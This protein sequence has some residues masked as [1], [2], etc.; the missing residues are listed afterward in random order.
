MPG[1]QPQGAFLADAFYRLLV[2]S[3]G[4]GVGETLTKERTILY[5]LL[6]CPTIL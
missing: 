2:G 4:S 3:N 5:D 1:G 6:V